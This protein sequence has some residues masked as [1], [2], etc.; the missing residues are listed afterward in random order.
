MTAFSARDGGSARQ[1]LYVTHRV[2]FPPDKGDRIRTYNTLRYLAER[3][4]VHLACLADEDVS[5]EALKTLEGLC[6][7]LVI[8]P[9][10]SGLRWLRAGWSLLTGGTAS[11][12]AFHS[13]A[14]AQKL[15]DWS[16][17]TRVRSCAG[18][19]LERCAV[20]AILRLAPGACRGGPR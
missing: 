11:V 18:F 10:S 12:G 3:H 8:I 6:R 4:H 2:P 20:S 17:D 14:L 16:I 1:L 9:V 13:K 15:Q 19:R 5:E 7:R